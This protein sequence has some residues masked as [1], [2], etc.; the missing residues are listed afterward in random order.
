MGEYNGNWRHQI[1]LR[2]DDS[3]AKT[4]F[5]KVNFQTFSHKMSLK[6]FLFSIWQEWSK[7]CY[8]ISRCANKED[9]G[10]QESCL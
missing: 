4:V 5:D 9:G 8:F 3:A 6:V 10:G 7:C 2:Q 1:C